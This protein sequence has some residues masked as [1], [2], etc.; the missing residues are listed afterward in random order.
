MLLGLRLN[1]I[2]LIESLDLSFEKGFSAFT[3]ETG[4]GKSIFLLAIDALL[5]AGSGTSFSRLMRVGSNCCSIE[6]CFLIDSSV[7]NWLE[8]NS[9]DIP[10]SELYI[11]RDWKA[12]GNRLINRIRLN[13]EIINRKQLLSL[14]TCLID[15]VQQGQSHQLLSPIYQ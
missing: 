12:K 11:S 8:E 13:G 5:G 15:L 2:A 10:E 7:R 9:F 14:R 4:A 3:G 6:G 1:N